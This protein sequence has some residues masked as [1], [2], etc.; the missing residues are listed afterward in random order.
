MED[1][2]LTEVTAWQLTSQT[3]IRVMA[4]QFI[5]TSGDS[6]L[7]ALTG[8]EHRIGRE[9]QELHGESIAPT[10]GDERT[11]GNTL[12]IQL[13]KTKEAQTFTAPDWAYRFNGPED[14]PNR[15]RGVSGHNFWWIELGGIQDTLRDAEKIRDDLY[16]TAYGVWDY[17]KNRSP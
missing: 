6:I 15:I 3:W 13:H 8:A 14:L 11:M 12:L 4:K 16:R 7:A 5:D 17:I 9:P 2:H 10:V 1:R